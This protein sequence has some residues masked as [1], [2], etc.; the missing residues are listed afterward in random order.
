MDG[1]LATPA[2]KA[3]GGWMDTIVNLIPGRKQAASAA[4]SDDTIKRT[5][6]Y[7]RCLNLDLLNAP[8]S[9]PVWALPIIV[10]PIAPPRSCVGSLHTAKNKRTA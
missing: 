10:S 3:A 6:E 2:S 5:H 4:P 9:M 8:V 1:M 7:L